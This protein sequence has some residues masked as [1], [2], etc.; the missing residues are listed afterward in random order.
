M[1]GQESTEALQVK[2]NRS[3]LSY[4]AG[5]KITGSVLFRNSHGKLILEDIFL[6][7]IGELGNSRS[8]TQCFLDNLDNSQP[9]PRTEHHRIPF[10][11][12]RLPIVQPEAGKVSI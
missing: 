2:F 12:V 11:N 10:M 8:E 5:E 1:G 3:N 7:F 4:F 9:D 6:D